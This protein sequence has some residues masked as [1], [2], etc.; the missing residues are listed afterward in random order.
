M[1]LDGVEVL[2]DEESDTDDENADDLQEDLVHMSSFYGILINILS[3]KN[4]V[5]LPY[6]HSAKVYPGAPNKH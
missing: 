6:Y 5:V 4:P 3:L 2:S 1:S